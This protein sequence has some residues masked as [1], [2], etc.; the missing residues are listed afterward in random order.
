MRV[1]K[2]PLG[3]KKIAHKITTITMS[4][5]SFTVQDKYKWTISPNW[6]NMGNQS[7]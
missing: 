6:Q 5:I 7:Q 3:T 2:T 1:I 4:I